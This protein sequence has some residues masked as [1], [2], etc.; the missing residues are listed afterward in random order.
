MEA[1]G[2]GRK[3][4]GGYYRITG[5]ETSPTGILCDFH[6]RRSGHPVLSRHTLHTMEIKK[7]RGGEAAPKP[8]KEDGG[9]FQVPGGPG[10]PFEVLAGRKP[11]RTSTC[12]N[13][14]IFF[15]SCQ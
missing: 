13:F 9:A 8:P 1:S 10:Q 3:K 2:F 14:L 15:F 12:E 5:P 11:V 6:D 7:R 4:E